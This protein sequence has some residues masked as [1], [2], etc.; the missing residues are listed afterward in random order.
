[1]KFA[2]KESTSVGIMN[3]TLLHHYSEERFMRIK[4]TMSLEMNGSYL[5]LIVYMLIGI[6]K[7][8]CLVYM[9]RELGRVIIGRGVL[10]AADDWLL[11]KGILSKSLCLIFCKGRGN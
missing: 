10:A 8:W 1:M 6:L 2:E 11:Q 9:L 5:P 7:L 3:G 4:P